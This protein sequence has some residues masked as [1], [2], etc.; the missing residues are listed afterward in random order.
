MADVP[1]FA[2][3]EAP[4]RRR[5][6]Q[7]IPPGQRCLSLSRCAVDH[8]DIRLLEAALDR[9]QLRAAPDIQARKHVIEARGNTVVKLLREFFAFGGVD[10]TLDQRTNGP[11]PFF[12]MRCLLGDVLANSEQSRLNVGRCHTPPI[13]RRASHPCAEIEKRRLGIRARYGSGKLIEHNSLDVRFAH[14]R[15][16]EGGGKRIGFTGIESIGLQ[17]LTGVVRWA[18]EETKARTDVTEADDVLERSRRS[19]QA[20]PGTDEEG[21]TLALQAGRRQRCA[22]AGLDLDGLDQLAA[23]IENLEIFRTLELNAVSLRRGV[24]QQAEERV[25]MLTSETP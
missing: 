18:L 9:L 23:L 24:R 14:F 5:R 1:W 16:A 3:L 19:A 7:E 12:V 11:E 21:V 8:H 4:G 25:Q 17:R 15:N 6:F 10:L 2:D 22:L 13:L 20:V